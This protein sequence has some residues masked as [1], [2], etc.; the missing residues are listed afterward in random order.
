[1]ASQMASQVQLMND[2]VRRS[3]F[4]AQAKPVFEFVFPLENYGWRA[5]DYCRSDF[6][7]QDQF[8]QN[9]PSFDCF[10][11]SDIVGYEK[12]SPGEL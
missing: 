8:A 6:L 4:N 3:N 1:M 2:S 10:P 11:E 12:V 5:C 9:Q 7:A